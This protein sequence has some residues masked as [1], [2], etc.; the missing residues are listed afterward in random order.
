MAAIRGAGRGSLLDRCE[1]S[2]AAANLS[3]ISSSCSKA[4]LFSPRSLAFGM[5]AAPAVR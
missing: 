4:R 5:P 1:K 2:L 3:P